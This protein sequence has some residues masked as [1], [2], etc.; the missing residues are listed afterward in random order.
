MLSPASG[1]DGTSVVTTPVI[2]GFGEAGDTLTLFDSGVA[3]ATGIVH[4]DGTWSVTTSALSLG[5]HNLAAQETDIAGDVSAVSAVL[6][7]TVSPLH[8]I[9][10]GD[11]DGDGRAD[12]V[13]TGG[14]QATV[15]LNGGNSFTQ[16]T[17]PGGHM[18]AE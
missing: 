12:L 8:Y 10:P 6:S 1:R 2:I 3:V 4:T 11:L 13:F 5:A 15:W 9:A 16:T 18:G 7:L 17:V 14:G